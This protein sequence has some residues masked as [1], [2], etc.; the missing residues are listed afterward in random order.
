MNCRSAVF[1]LSVIQFL[2][3]VEFVKPMKQDFAVKFIGFRQW[4]LKM[5]GFLEKVDNTIEK[6]YMEGSNQTVL[7]LF[8]ISKLC[9]K[10]LI[11][12]TDCRIWPQCK[13]QNGFVCAWFSC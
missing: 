1:T 13:E 3:Q 9:G 11:C 2:L 4:N 5:K 7:S 12:A 8:P 6:L 10:C